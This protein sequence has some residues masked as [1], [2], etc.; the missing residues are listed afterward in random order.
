MCL[1]NRY[2]GHAAPLDGLYE[3][4]ARGL[5]L[6]RSTHVQQHTAVIVSRYAL[7]G[8]YVQYVVKSIGATT[9]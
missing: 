2:K 1:G 8:A 6:V 5:E 9:V 3:E 4:V 7:A